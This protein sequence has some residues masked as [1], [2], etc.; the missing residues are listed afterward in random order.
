MS[1]SRAE[2]MARRAYRSRAPGATVTPSRPGHDTTGGP[3]SLAE[4]AG[5]GGGCQ[6][7][8]LAPQ[9]NEK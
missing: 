4:S 5:R 3:R 8:Y 9:P 6:N 7:T 1:G 2:S